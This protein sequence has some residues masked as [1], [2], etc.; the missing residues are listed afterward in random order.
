[1]KRS[2]VLL[3]TVCVLVAGCDE[4]NGDPGPSNQPLV[5]TANMTAAQETSAV[6]G[7]EQNATGTA[8]VT[9]TPTRDS[10]GAIT[11]GTAQFQFSVQGLTSTSNII[12]AH[13]H[14]GAAGVAGGAVINSQ[15]S[16]ASA[17]PTPAGSASFDRSGLT[18]DNAAAV[19]NAIVANPAG[20]YFNVHTTANPGGV[21]RG[22]L[23]AGN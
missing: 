3:L 22:Q 2:G 23:Q 10:S 17:I 13:V 15:L 16:A 12:L 11:G 8:T 1:M 20:Y 21:V 19:I 5:F 18:F 14:T 7:G 6:G 4:E 9:I